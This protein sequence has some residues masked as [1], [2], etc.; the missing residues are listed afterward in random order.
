LLV[1]PPLLVP[2]PE[3]LEADIRQ[4]VLDVLFLDPIGVA[5]VLD[6]LKSIGQAVMHPGFRGDYA[7]LQAA[8][9]DHALLFI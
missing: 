6:L 9:P 1:N 4:V 2:L 7:K 5:T 8:D 3:V